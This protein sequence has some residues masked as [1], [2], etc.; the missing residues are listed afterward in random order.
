M[1]SLGGAKMKAGWKTTEFWV[2]L[3]AIGLDAFSPYVLGAAQ[4]AGENTFTWA[5]ALIA[6]AYAISRGLA[7]RGSTIMLGGNHRS[8]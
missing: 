6:G 3:G 5:S 8:D 1:V 2:A 4:S 7:K